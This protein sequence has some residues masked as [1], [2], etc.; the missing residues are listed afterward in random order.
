MNAKLVIVADL[1]LL[2][3]YREVQG[4]RDHQPHL[5]LV[6][7]LETDAASERLSEQVSDQAGRFP[8]GSGPDN[9]L[10]DL[11][12]GERL[13]LEAEQTRRLLGQ[14]ARWINDLLADASIERCS[15]AA[16]APIHRQLFEALEPQ[17][18]EKIGQ[19]LP[20]N[21]TRTNPLELPAHFAN[22]VDRSPRA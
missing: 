11:S 15:L 6:K 22:A 14:L 16:S 20:L 17:A 1:G 12:A 2:R 9:I 3:A 10:G 13:N 4:R 5:K 18:R 8:R 19:L 21:L 7:E